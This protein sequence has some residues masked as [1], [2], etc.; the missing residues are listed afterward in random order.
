MRGLLAQLLHIPHFFLEDLWSGNLSEGD[1]LYAWLFTEIMQRTIHAKD[2]AEPTPKA[3]RLMRMRRINQRRLEPV[4]PEVGGYIDDPF[5]RYIYNGGTVLGRSLIYLYTRDP[6]M[7]T[8][9]RS[10]RE[11]DIKGVRWNAK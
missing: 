3:R 10:C 4:A 11:H 1:C 8:A 5:D 6:E 7:R 2:G 9:L